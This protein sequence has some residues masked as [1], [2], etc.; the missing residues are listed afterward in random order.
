MSAATESTSVTTTT[1]SNRDKKVVY[2]SFDIESD[3]RSPAHNSMISLGV[4]AFVKDRD[5]NWYCEDEFKVN[6]KPILVYNGDDIRR[7]RREADPTTYEEFWSKWPAKWE[8]CKVDAQEPAVAMDRLFRFLGTVAAV[9]PGHK[10]VWVAGPASFDWQWLNY[11]YY[12]FTDTTQHKLHY[13]ADCLSTLNRY[14][15]RMKGI[16]GAEYKK[17]SDE[18][19]GRPNA[20]PHDA[21]QDAIHQGWAWVNLLDK[22]MT[23]A[24]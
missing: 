14:Y 1:T 5:G 16:R 2:L 19:A 12:K 23:E 13:A 9:H 11:Y 22:M 4:A 3:G 24:A 20:D 21:L 6:I 15:C 17:F 18:L 8:A 10:M 7:H